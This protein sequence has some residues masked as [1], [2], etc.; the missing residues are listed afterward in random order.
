MFNKIWGF[1]SGA[2]TLW[3]LLP[4]TVTAS[5]AATAWLVVMAVVGYFQSVPIFWL[6]VG[7]PVA[8]AAIFT[9]LLRFAE[10]RAKISAAGALLFDGI[11][12]GIDL[13]NDSTGAPVGIEKAQVRLNL[14]T[15]AVFPVSF[16]VDEMRSTFEGRYPPNKPRDNDRGIVRRG[17]IKIYGD[18]LIDMGGAP[19]TPQLSGTAEFK[20]RYGHPGR[21][22]YPLQ[23]R[24]QF[25]LMYEPNLKG[26]LPIGHKDLA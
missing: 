1:I 21:E 5:V 13:I 23:G 20:I 6:M 4:S 10:W 2:S 11:L 25:H 22:K 7:L 18:N 8:G 14:K 19:I 9:W 3:G 12:P 26:Y 17:E 24:V 15:E 16:I